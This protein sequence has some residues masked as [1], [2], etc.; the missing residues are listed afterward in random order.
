MRPASRKW[1][2]FMPDDPGWSTRPARARRKPTWSIRLYDLAPDLPIGCGHG[3]GTRWAEKGRPPASRDAFSAGTAEGR[4]LVSSGMVQP[5]R[6]PRART[7][8][9][10]MSWSEPRRTEPRKSCSSSRTTV[11]G[12]CCPEHR[13]STRAARRRPARTSRSAKPAHGRAA[14]STSSRA[15]S[16]LSSRGGP[17]RLWLATVGPECGETSLGG[18][19]RAGGVRWLS[20]RG[21]RHRAV[22]FDSP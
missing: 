8:G 16:R 13:Q 10:L 12:G 15:A 2:Q 21:M 20:A 5:I 14:T 7:V 3:G 6:R 22:A 4:R 9:K 11:P 1:A 18:A 17:K 19:E